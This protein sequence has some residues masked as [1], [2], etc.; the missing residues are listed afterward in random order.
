MAYRTRVRTVE[1]FRWT[2][3]P[4]CEWPEWATLELLQ[5]SGT[6]LYAYTTNGP[7]RVHRGDWCIMGAKEIYPC[8]DA[9]FRQRYEEIPAPAA[10]QVTAD[11][12]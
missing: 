4:R 5:E 7:V 3:Q 1:A 8:T 6:A 2:G 9:E 12:A 10:P 11:V